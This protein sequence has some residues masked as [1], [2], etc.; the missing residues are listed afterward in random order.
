MDVP[1]YYI[2]KR[3]LPESQ[4]ETIKAALSVTPCQAVVISNLSDESLAIHLAPVILTAKDDAVALDLARQ[5][6]ERTERPLLVIGTA[7]LLDAVYPDGHQ[8]S[9]LNA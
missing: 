9:V 2:V 4:I 6:A 3:G 7:D 8:E 5:W 1:L